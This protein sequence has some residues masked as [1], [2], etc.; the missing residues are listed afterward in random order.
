MQEAAGMLAEAEIKGSASIA[1]VSEE[2][3]A[4]SCSSLWLF[5]KEE[6]NEKVEKRNKAI[7]KAA[8]L[9]IFKAICVIEITI[10]A[11]KITHLIENHEDRLG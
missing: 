5:P 2:T 10:Y 7:N 11:T 3:F 4:S 1:A 8:C 6:L 9:L